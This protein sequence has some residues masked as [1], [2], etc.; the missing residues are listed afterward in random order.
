MATLHLLSRTTE[1]HG[2]AYVVWKLHNVWRVYLRM[3]RAL[4]TERPA[5]PSAFTGLPVMSTVFAALNALNTWQGTFR[6]KFP[7]DNERLA[8]YT[9]RHIVSL[10]Q[11]AWRMEHQIPPR[12]TSRCI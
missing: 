11:R 7:A 8:T 12:N 5:M 10:W 3:V 4:S 6:R 9:V 1:L 2:T